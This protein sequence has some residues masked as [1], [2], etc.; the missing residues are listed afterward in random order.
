ME[1]M[2]QLTKTEPGGGGVME[3]VTRDE[4]VAPN[5][6]LPHLMGTRDEAC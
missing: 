4:V 1:E 2:M 6:E 5:L 3:V